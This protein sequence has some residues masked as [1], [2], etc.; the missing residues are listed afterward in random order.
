[1][2]EAQH[3]LLVGKLKIKTKPLFLLGEFLELALEIISRWKLVFLRLKKK[4]LK[5]EML[6]KLIEIAMKDE[7]LPFNALLSLSLV[8]SSWL[9]K[10]ETEKIT[11]TSWWGWQV[12]WGGRGRGECNGMLII[13]S[14]LFNFVRDVE[15]PL[16]NQLQRSCLLFYYGQ[17]DWG[18]RRAAEQVVIQG[19]KL[20]C[21]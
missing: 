13:S 15:V 21:L 3:L 19:I 2:W 9:N 17:R 16:K 8:L 20:L 7:L 11:T 18:D 12:R 4:S 14:S 6:T 10:K 1:L 5:I